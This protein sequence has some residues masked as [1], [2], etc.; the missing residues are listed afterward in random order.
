MHGAWGHLGWRGPGTD[1]RQAGLRLVSQKSH[2][3]CSL[4]TEELVLL[5]E[6]ETS[7]QSSSPRSPK[8][9]QGTERKVEKGEPER[10]LANTL[11][12]GL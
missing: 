10:I 8:R 6:L 3:V 12:E 2:R 7:G 5:S 11:I 1:W 9:R 4:S